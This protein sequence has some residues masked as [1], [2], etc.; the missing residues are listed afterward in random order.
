MHGRGPTITFSDT[1]AKPRA[2]RDVA[3]ILLLARGQG[4]GRGSFHAGAHA[5][6]PEE[7]AMYIPDA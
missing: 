2:S 6:A 7:L 4:C 1:H 5:R 3:S